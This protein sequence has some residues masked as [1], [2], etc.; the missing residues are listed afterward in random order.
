MKLICLVDVHDGRSL[1][2]GKIYEV[3]KLE[4]GWFGL[5]DE[6]GE[7]YIYPPHLFE[8]INPKTGEISRIKRGGHGQSNLDFMDENGL[9]YNIEMT[10]ENGVRVGNIPNHKVKLKRTGSN[11]SWFPTTWSNEEIVNAAEFVAGLPENNS[12]ADDVVM[13]GKYKDVRVGVIKSY[14]RISSIFPDLIQ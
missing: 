10:Y 2:K 7:R 12:V 4:R 6:S 9:K 14:G 8:K 5:A 1:K 3:N 13:Y 11:H